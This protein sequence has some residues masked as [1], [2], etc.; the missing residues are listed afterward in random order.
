MNQKMPE[1][2][3]CPAILGLFQKRIDG[4]DSLLELARLRFR[5]A[6]MGTELYAETPEELEYLLH[7]RPYNERQAAVHLK[8]GLNIIKAEDRS[9]IADFAARAEDRVFCLIVHDQP[10]AATRFE[11]Y[12]DALR[13][14][15]SLL[16]NPKAANIF[17]E[18][19]S[20]LDTA[21]YIDIFHEIRGLE[22]ISACIDTGHVGIW[23]ARRVFRERHQDR[24]ICDMKVGDPDTRGL[25]KD[26]AH[27]VDAALPETLRLIR[28]LGTLGKPLHFHL[29]DGH[30]LSESSPFGVSDHMSFLETIPLP[31]DFGGRGSAHLIYGLAG[32]SAIV[33]TAL[34]SLPTEKISFSLEIHPSEGRIPLGD[35]SYLF[36]HWE[37]KVNAERMNF[38]L[39]VLSQNKK[40]VEEACRR[41]HEKSGRR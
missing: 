19:A 15:D 20:G 35:A 28:E 30:P 32:L 40:L 2:A 37:E 16:R 8:R 17:I 7:F 1:R 27:A 34:G 18:Y 24:D 26:I 21:V 5:Q 13:K 14:L 3:S 4:D 6:G 33:D 10:E 22:S 36:N 31:F 12:A 39:S 38:W 41:F 9:T 11:D 29:H 23:K 25:M